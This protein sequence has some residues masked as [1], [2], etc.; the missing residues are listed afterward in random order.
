MCIVY[1]ILKH[2]QDQLDTMVRRCLRCSAFWQIAHRRSARVPRPTCRQNHRLPCLL[3]ASAASWNARAP[4]PLISV[5][6]GTS[7]LVKCRSRFMERQ[8]QMILA[9]LR[10]ASPQPLAPTP[11]RASALHPTSLVSPSPPRA[12][13]TRTKRVSPSRSRSR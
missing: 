11:A 5:R 4:P 1:V 8:P 3:I 12:A 9:C 10:A 6:H 2:P 7:P 13:I